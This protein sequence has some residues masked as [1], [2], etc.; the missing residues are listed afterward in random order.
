MLG[1]VAPAAPASFV[2]PKATM[3]WH[4]YSMEMHKQAMEV[5]KQHMEREKEWY[6]TTHLLEVKNSK[7]IALLK[8]ENDGQAEVITAQYNEL[9]EYKD[10][11]AG[12]DSGVST[13]A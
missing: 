13:V 4:K 12:G 10:F 8:A 1:R 3:D 7:T 2:E 11:F 6:A 9:T 5:H